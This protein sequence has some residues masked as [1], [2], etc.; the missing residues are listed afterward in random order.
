MSSET[1]TCPGCDQGFSLQGYQSHLALS[2]DPLCCAVFEKLK[3]AHDAY[4][5]LI[6]TQDNSRF[7]AESDTD[8]I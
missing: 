7:G 8:V 6:G 2:R 4:K 3:K 5:L 1:A